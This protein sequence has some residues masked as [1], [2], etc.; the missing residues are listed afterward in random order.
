MRRCFRMCRSRVLCSPP[1]RDLGMLLTGRSTVRLGEGMRADTKWMRQCAS[2]MDSTASQ[3]Q[4]RLATADEG[5][6]NL[7]SSAPGWSFTGSIGQLE[8]RWENL[9]KL[10]RDD[11]GEAAENIR[12]NASK[13]DGNENW[14]TETWQDIFQ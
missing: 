9:N 8:E 10:L 5:I 13:H 12:F 11:L 7:R 4:R 3:I 14:I 2:E 6:G 1:T